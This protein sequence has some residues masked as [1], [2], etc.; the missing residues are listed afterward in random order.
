MRSLKHDF[1]IATSVLLVAALLLALTACHRPQEVP[2][3]VTEM[4]AATLANKTGDLLDLAIQNTISAYDVEILE[5]LRL[6]VHYVLNII[7]GEGGSHYDEIAGRPPDSYGLLN[8]AR[9]LLQKLREAEMDEELV[10]TM[11]H[12]L[13]FIEFAV[14]RLAHSLNLFENKEAVLKE[15]RQAMAFLSAAAGRAADSTVLGG[16]Q[17]VQARLKGQK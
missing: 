16:V 5:E 6:K 17:A 11:G 14:E 2:Q 8:Y 3:E 9:E 15:V 10:R 4:D 12:A 13:S 1:V 7:E